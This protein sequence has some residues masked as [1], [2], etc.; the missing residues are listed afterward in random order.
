LRDSL[1]NTLI[2]LFVVGAITILVSMIL[3]LDPKVGDGKKSLKVRFANIAGIAD[4]TRVTYAGKPVGEVVAIHEIPHARTEQIDESGRIYC[5]LLTLKLDS[6][7][8]IYDTDE[9]AIR[10]TGLM[11][12]KSIAI[13]PKAAPPGKKA[14]LITDEILIANSIDPLENTFNQ[15]TKTA[16][17]MDTLV[18][19]V[20]HWFKKNEQPLTYTVDALHQSLT[21]LDTA[22]VSFDREKIL[23]ILHDFLGKA[24][25]L[26]DNLRH[27]ADSFNTD[28]AEALRNLNHISRDLATGTGTLGRFINQE[29]FYLRLT[30]LLNKGETLMNDINHYGLLFQY[31]KHWQRS[32]T[33][34]ANLLHSLTSPK[35]FRSYFESEIDT[36]NTSLG[37]LTQLL[38]KSTDEQASIAQNPEFKKQFGLLLRQVESL[39]SALKL[40]NE[41]LTS[42]MPE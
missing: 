34:R 30:S 8:S 18:S 5:Y 37:R 32:R 12:E 2:G 21:H 14:K 35:E 16:N 15:I 6:S 28:G 22:L 33:K 26:T 40:Y 13:L 19:N 23:P 29:D 4:G 24:T 31:D 39:T 7:T 38:E 9:I 42:E 10:S 1:K 36:M 20:N 41:N 3:F 17:R 11:G 25:T 27:T